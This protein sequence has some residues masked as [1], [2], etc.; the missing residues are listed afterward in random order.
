MSITHIV[1]SCS[2]HLHYSSREQTSE[3]GGFT[4]FSVPILLNTLLCRGPW[5]ARLDEHLPLCYLVSNMNSI[6]IG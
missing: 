1:M 2:M 6:V 4:G 5:R 3:V